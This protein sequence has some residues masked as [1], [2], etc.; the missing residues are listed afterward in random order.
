MDLRRSRFRE[1]RDVDF[2]ALNRFSGD[3]F[4]CLLSEKGSSGI[5]ESRTFKLVGRDCSD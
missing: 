2:L 1:D 5:R 3:S 4:S